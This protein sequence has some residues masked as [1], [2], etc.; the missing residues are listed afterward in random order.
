LLQPGELFDAF[1]GSLEVLAFEQGR[2][3]APK[4]AI[5]QRLCAAAAPSR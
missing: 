5:L 1:A 2:T 3:F 4:P